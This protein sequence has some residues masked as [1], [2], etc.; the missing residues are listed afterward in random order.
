MLLEKYLN[1]IKQRGYMAGDFE[2]FMNPDSKEVREVQMGSEGYRFLIDFKNKNSYVISANAFHETLMDEDP[3]L[4]SFKEFW[5]GGKAKDRI[6]TGDYTKGSKQWNSDAMYQ[7]LYTNDEL[8]NLLDKDWK[9]LRHTLDI[10]EV[11]NLI[12]YYMESRSQR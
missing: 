2:V 1:T 3:V 10:K 8:T 4:P 11:Q 5:Y 12:T 6:F 9:W 7:G